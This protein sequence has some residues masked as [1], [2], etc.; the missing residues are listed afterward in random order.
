[1]Q[2]NRIRLFAAAAALT[3]ALALSACIPPTPEPTPAPSPAPTPVAQPAPVAPPPVAVPVHANW[4]DAPQTPGDWFYRT[5]AGQRIAEFRSPAGSPV[6]ILSCTAE[7]EINLSVMGRLPRTTA[8]VIRTETAERSLPASGNETL[9]V[10]ALSP[11]DTLL[12]A[13]AF[14]KGRFAVEP[15]GGSSLYLPAWPEVTR[16]IEE[17]RR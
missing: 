2:L 7:R 14:T 11:T 9:A 6:A 1:M 5:A 16:V 12:D 8:I 13:M 4:M 17:C 10:T 15:Q 3:G